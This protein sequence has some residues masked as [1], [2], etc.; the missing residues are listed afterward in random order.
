[1]FT[2]TAHSYI[3]WARVEWHCEQSWA[4]LLPRE[5]EEQH[6]TPSIWRNTADDAV[7]FRS[8]LQDDLVATHSVLCALFSGADQEAA[9]K[10]CHH[11]MN[12]TMEAIAQ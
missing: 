11:T 1:M 8:T 10:L 5:A 7:A 12:L 2:R 4:D 3:R 9:V 6:D